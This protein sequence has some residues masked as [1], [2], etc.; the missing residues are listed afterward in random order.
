MVLPA[1]LMA[2]SKEDA[3]LNLATVAVLMDSEYQ[4]VLN[5][6]K[7]WLI[8]RRLV[9]LSGTVV[10]MDVVIMSLRL[11]LRARQLYLHPPQCH[12]L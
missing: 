12:L 1:I 9:A 6:M 3:A 7:R 4:L 2:L 11:L 10:R 8:H 5:Q